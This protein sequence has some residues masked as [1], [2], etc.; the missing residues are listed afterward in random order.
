MIPRRSP[1]AA[2]AGRKKIE[3]TPAAPRFVLPGGF[4]H[5]NSRRMH[6]TELRQIG[7]IALLRHLPE[8]PAVPRNGPV[9]RSRP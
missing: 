7:G 3:N 9:N 8:K 4:P 6:L 5:G 2:R 1:R